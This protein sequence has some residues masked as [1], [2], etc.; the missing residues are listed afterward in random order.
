MPTKPVDLL[1]GVILSVGFIREVG[2]KIS[3]RPFVWC[4]AIL[5]AFI[6]PFALADQ[7]QVEPSTYG[8][9]KWRLVGPFRGGRVITVAGVPAQSARPKRPADRGG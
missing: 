2:V 5:W 8:G 7:Q 3:R 1:L 9:L 4:A 6:A